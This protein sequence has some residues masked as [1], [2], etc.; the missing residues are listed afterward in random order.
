MFKH[1]ENL[2]FE[3]FPIDVSY[4]VHRLYWT[5]IHG[6]LFIYLNYFVKLGLLILTQHK[7]FLTIKLYR[8]TDKKKIVQKN[9]LKQQVAYQILYD[10]HCKNRQ[11]LCLKYSILGFR[12]LKNYIILAVIVKKK[13]RQFVQN[14][15]KRRKFL[16]R[17]TDSYNNKQKREEENY[18]TGCRRNCSRNIAE[19]LQCISVLC[20]ENKF[21]KP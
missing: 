9:Y 6:N 13:D 12:I 5:L 2:P 14:Y 1:A 16:A 8:H 15:S 18:S 7:Q 19:L 3:P 4:G 17:K 10:F 21:A 11:I 20:L